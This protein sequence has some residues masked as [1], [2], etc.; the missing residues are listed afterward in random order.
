MALEQRN[1]RNR[2][3]VKAKRQKVDEASVAEQDVEMQESGAPTPT[4]GYCWTHGSSRNRR[5]TS[6]TC[7]NKHADHQDAATFTDKM[8]GSTEVIEVVTN[9]TSTSAKTPRSNAPTIGYCWTHGSSKNR[10]H[11]SMT[12]NNKHADHQ[13]AATVTNKMGGSTEENQQGVS[14]PRP[15]SDDDDDATERSYCWTHG[16]CKNLSHTSMTCNR[17]QIDHR[18][19]ATVTNKMGGSTKILNRSE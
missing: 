3:A 15:T 4:M 16:I 8:G 14:N 9:P 18:D 17:K 1:A 19:E 6:M 11:T 2:R 13:D 5:H 10:R 7:N 12:C